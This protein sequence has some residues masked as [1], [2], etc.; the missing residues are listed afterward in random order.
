MRIAPTH[1]AAWLTPNATPTLYTLCASLGSYFSLDKELAVSIQTSRG[2]C[3]IG[4]LGKRLLYQYKRTVGR[5]GRER[6]GKSRDAMCHCINTNEQW[7]SEEEGES[8]RKRRAAHDIDANIWASGS[9]SVASEK[10]TCHM[11][12][13]FPTRKFP[14]SYHPLLSVF[15]RF[16]S[17]LHSTTARLY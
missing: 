12:T 13:E 16:L 10:G 6:R 2:S 17:L 3:C 14:V 8:V 1:C 5:R 9:R 4:Q 11:R 15:A 7:W